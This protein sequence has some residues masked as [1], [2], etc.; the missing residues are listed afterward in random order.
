MTNKTKCL[1]SLLEDVIDTRGWFSKSSVDLLILNFFKILLDFLVLLLVIFLIN[2]DLVFPLS[3]FTL[4]SWNELTALLALIANVIENSISW[5]EIIFRLA[6]LSALRVLQNRAVVLWS[7]GPVVLDERNLDGGVVLVDV[8]VN[9]EVWRSALGIEL[10]STGVS[11]RQVEDLKSFNLT[12]VGEVELL[13]RTALVF[14]LWAEGHGVSLL[15]VVG[16]ASPALLVHVFAVFH[17]L[18]A[19]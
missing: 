9:L 10:V 2:L 3:V 15:S 17:V 6:L 19:V 11:S 1:V 14:A 16:R 5:W 8:F 18:A 12:I 7:M 13:V 4:S